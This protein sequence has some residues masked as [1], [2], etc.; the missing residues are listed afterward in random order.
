VELQLSLSL[1]LKIQSQQSFSAIIWVRW[2]LN[3]IPNRG[4]RGKE[5][6]LA[7]AQQKEVTIDGAFSYKWQANPNGDVQIKAKDRRG[8]LLEKT[9]GSVKSN[10]SD[11]DLVYFEQILP[12]LQASSQKEAVNSLKSTNHQ[13]R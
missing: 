4:V 3:L 10:M 11:R 6:V 1:T 9:G 8:N 13:E 5:E 7:V 2:R 12:K